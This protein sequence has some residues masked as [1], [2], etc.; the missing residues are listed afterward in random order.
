MFPGALPHKNSLWLYKHKVIVTPADG[1]GDVGAADYIRINYSSPNIEAFERF[2]NV[3]PKAIAE[4]QN[5]IYAEPV[6]NY[7]KK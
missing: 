7:F 5:N 2:R 3:S 6:A 4:A 1:L